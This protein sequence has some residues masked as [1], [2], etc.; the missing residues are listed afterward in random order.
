MSAHI[1][2]QISLPHR[3]LATHADVVR[4]LAET[5]TGAY[6]LRPRRLDDVMVIVPGI[7]TI[8]MASLGERYVAVDH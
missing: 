6:G 3:V 1:S 2:L 5:A 8:E 4:S 7:L